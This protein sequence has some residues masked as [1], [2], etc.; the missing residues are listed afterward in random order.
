[1]LLRH[2][3]RTQIYPALCIFVLGPII[4][5]VCKGM[6]TGKGGKFHDDYKLLNTSQKLQ[7]PFEACTS[8]HIHVT[9]LALQIRMYITADDLTVESYC[10]KWSEVTSKIS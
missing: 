10:K 9:T 1:M 5:L 3:S 8:S 7:R 2:V 6:T 4:P